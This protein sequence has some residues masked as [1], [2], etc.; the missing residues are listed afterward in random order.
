M[1]QDGPRPTGHLAGCVERAELG[2]AV[3]VPGGWIGGG[4][5]VRRVDGQGLVHT[6][7]PDTVAAADHSDA[8]EQVEGVEMAKGHEEGRGRQMGS[9]E[10]CIPGRPGAENNEV[11]R[12]GSAGE[13][14][15][16]QTG[17]ERPT[18]QRC[19][20]GRSGELHAGPEGNVGGDAGPNENLRPD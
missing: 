14:M 15:P 5:N 20:I 1:W 2:L 11:G 10:G 4:E 9:V 12:M 8:A 13:D 16:V 19:P 7:L 18:I 6:R 3:P 17:C